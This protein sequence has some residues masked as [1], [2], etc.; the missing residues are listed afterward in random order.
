[1][2]YAKVGG[3]MSAIGIIILWF[4][5]YMNILTIPIW[6]IVFIVGLIIMAGSVPTSMAAT[7]SPAIILIGLMG[8]VLYY[9]LFGSD[10]LTRTLL[11][12]LIG[13]CVI[14]GVLYPT[15]QKHWK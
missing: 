5:P 10:L 2:K 3:I 11:G 13:V 12:W 4:M 14:A 7:V 9:Q 1:M 15:I 6:S 8:V